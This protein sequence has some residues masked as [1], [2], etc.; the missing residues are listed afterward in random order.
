MGGYDSGFEGL[1]LGFCLAV[2][3]QVNPPLAAGGDWRMLSPAMTVAAILWSTIRVLLVT[4]VGIGV[5]HRVSLLWRRWRDKDASMADGIM[6]AE[7]L[8]MLPTVTVQLPIY[9]ERY[10]VTRLLESVG[11]LDYPRQRLQVQVLDDSDV[12]DGSSDAVDVGAE[13]LREQGWE[14]E[15]LRRQQRVGFKAGAL[16]AGLSSASGELVAILD[17]D[18]VPQEDFLRR[19]VAF[20]GA[21]DSRWVGMVQARWGFLN[22]NANWLTRVQAWF[23]DAHFR[24]EHAARWRSGCCFN[25]NGT[26]G[27][28]RRECIEDAGGWQGD[29]L[30]EDLDL[31]YRAQVKGW[32][33]VYADDVVVPSEL[34]SSWTAFKNQ[35]FRWA[36]GATQVAGKLMPTIWGRES[37]LTARAKWEA[38]LHLTS[39][40]A[41]LVFPVLLLGGAAVSLSGASPGDGAGVLLR[42]VCGLAMLTALAFFAASMFLPTPRPF[43]VRDGLALLLTVPVA[44]GLAISNSRA[45]V[46]G[47]LGRQSPFERT[48]KVGGESLDSGSGNRSGYHSVGSTA[49]SVIELIC[50]LALLAGLVASLMRV[51]IAWLE[52]VLL[53]PV[54]VGFLW[55]GLASLGEQIAAR[56]K[57]RQ[58]EQ[59]GDSI[60]DDESL[61][62]QA[63]KSADISPSTL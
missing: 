55:C 36:K 38:T 53:V 25:F 41:Y 32:R 52:V 42:C 9:N 62:D 56:K 21:P 13:K 47:W 27:I 19:M 12:G 37:R 60:R 16:Q 26:A 29:T 2:V 24:I 39:Q 46:E 54:V 31:S 35:Q 58:L 49:W 40:A 50:G 3:R 7:K 5:W 43:R 1:Y 30:T 57:R 18:F 20:F 10:V 28:W 63:E 15:V 51:E 48:P 11:N 34:P 33:F 45:V 44:I 61:R 59:I 8:Q 14:V 4:I 6:E 23:L 22:A 17:A